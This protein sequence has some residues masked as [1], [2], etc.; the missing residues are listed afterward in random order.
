MEETSKARLR[1]FYVRRRK[2]L[3]EGL[4]AS[5]DTRIRAAIRSLPAYRATC[6]AAF[7]V[8]LGAEP[9]LSPLFG[10]KRTFLP[11]YNP[12]EKRYELVEIG[13]PATELAPGRYGIPEPRPDLPAADREFVEREVLFFVPAVACD[14]NGT[15][16]GRG[17]GFY[18]RLL[19]GVRTAP[20]GVIYACQLADALL[21]RE[22]HD[23]PMGTVVTEE[24]ILECA[25]SISDGKRQEQR[26]NE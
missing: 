5:F 9:D 1:E 21:P 22:E 12:A 26:K 19:A 18:D 15:R 25:G 2:D 7:F 8:R 17:G 4:R 24:G 14:R 23:H 20:A 13:N 6:C 3:T 16:L 10:E 11:R